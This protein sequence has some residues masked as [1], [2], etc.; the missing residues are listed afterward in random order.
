MANF[1]SDN[2]AGVHPQVLA[3][4]S[5]CNEGAAPSYGAD[6]WSQALEARLAQLFGVKVAVGLV[7]SGTAANALALALFTPPYGA[8]FCHE[9]AHILSDEYGAPGFFTGGAQLWPLAGK[10][11]KIQPDTLG[12][13]LAQA[14][15]KLVK[16]AMLSLTQAT[17]S[18]ALYSA[19]ELSALC[20]LAH[21][22][23]LKVHMDGARFAGSAVALGGAAE[24]SWQR[25]VDVLSFGGTKGGCMN[26][27]AVVVFDPAAEA[28]DILAL[29][30]KQ[31]GHTASKMR[32]Q[33]A[34]F[35]GW[36][37]GGLWLQLATHAGSM[38]QLLAKWVHS[39]TG[40][41]PLHPVEANMVF[42]ALPAEA[43]ARV[44]QAHEFLEWHDGSCRFVMSHATKAADV[45][46]LAD[47]IKAALA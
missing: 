40:L 18:G 9:H 15:A 33:A 8:V 4:L 13:A 12:A 36:L 47:S 20:E 37:E 14:T 26:A 16:P 43:A 30:R 35:H 17:E 5:S 34:Q 11:G 22:A 6:G 28:A 7:S 1:T 10:H 3:A 38:A 39:S 29:R 24:A 42:Y 21:A 41:M 45:M 46:A 2:T 32:Y 44:A 23:G 19:E 31:S 27:E 25:G